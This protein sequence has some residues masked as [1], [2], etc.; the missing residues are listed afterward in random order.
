MERSKSLRS[1]PG[2]CAIGPEAVISTSTRPLPLP[3]AANPPL[4]LPL[5][6]EL[7]DT[8]SYGTKMI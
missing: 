1:P 4:P 5:P 6:E 7:D 2:P 8:S 3:L